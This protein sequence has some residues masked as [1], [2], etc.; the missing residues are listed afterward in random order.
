MGSGRFMKGS[1]VDWL[2]VSQARRS[3]RELSSYRLTLMFDSCFSPNSIHSTRCSWNRF[4]STVQ[5]SP[6]AT[7]PLKHEM[8]T[9]WQQ[10]SNATN[11]GTL[12]HTLHTLVAASGVSNVVGL[13]SSRGPN[14]EMRCWFSSISLQSGLRSAEEPRRDCFD[15]LFRGFLPGIS[16]L[17]VQL[18]IWR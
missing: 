5:T 13:Q 9:G 17:P 1:Y 16:Y 3:L 14:P 4:P 7:E 10:G 6:W 12:P 2:S 11:L 8:Q 15:C 18:G